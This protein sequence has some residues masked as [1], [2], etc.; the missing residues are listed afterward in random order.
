MRNFNPEK[1]FDADKLT[2]IFTVLS[3]VSLVDDALDILNI[4]YIS[5]LLW[6][7]K[8]KFGHINFCRSP[9]C[10]EKYKKL[11]EKPNPLPSF[12]NFKSS[13]K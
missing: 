6:I 13:Q 5:L 4:S 3:F 9:F 10:L 2:I 11:H 7:I 1:F 12:F 8:L